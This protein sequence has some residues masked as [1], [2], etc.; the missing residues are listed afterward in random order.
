MSL[1]KFTPNL[2]SVADVQIGELGSYP[3]IG[4]KGITQIVGGKYFSLLG[5]F[6]DADF[7]SSNVHPYIGLLSF[8]Q[9]DLTTVVDSIRY[10]HNY[11]SL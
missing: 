8:D 2:N 4:V 7:T 9:D 10:G 6:H 1:T 5:H 3:A 11:S